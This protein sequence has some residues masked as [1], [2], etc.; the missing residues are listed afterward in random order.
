MERWRSLADKTLDVG[1]FCGQEAYIGLDLATKVDIAA[2]VRLFWA[3]IDGARHY[4]A[5]PR[6]YA[7]EAALLHSKNAKMYAGWAEGGYLEVMDGEEIALGQIEDDVKAMSS[8]HPVREVAYDPWQATQLAQGLRK[9][10]VEAVEYRNTVPNMCPPMR[11]LEGA[12]A[13]GRFHH[14]DNPVFNWMASN[15][16]AKED[17]KENVFPRKELPENKIDGM[18]ALFMAMGRAMHAEQPK[19]AKVFYL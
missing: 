12:I 8:Q 5:F 18:V 16:V 13:S 3:E 7:P 14:P 10:R 6:L 1:D 11:E 15:V 4:Y 2:L 17:A 19:K 9:E